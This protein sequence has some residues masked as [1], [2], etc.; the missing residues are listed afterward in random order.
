MLHRSNILTRTFGLLLLL[1]WAVEFSLAVEN[2]L[3][4][5]RREL[6]AAED[7]DDKP[8]I[9]EIARRI[10]VVTPTDDSIWDKLAANQLA[11]E[12]LDRL[13]QTLNAW[14]KVR[15]IPVAGIQDFRGDLAVRRNQ[16]DE[17]ERHWLAFLRSKPAREDAAV[18]YDKLAAASVEQSR[19]IENEKYC[20]QAIAARDSPARRVTHAAAL[21][22]LH[23]W[24]AAY[25]EMVKANKMDSAD[26]AV[27]EWLP[28]FEKLREF[29][30][31]IK[32]WDY[33]LTQNPNDAA[34]LLEQ[35]HLFTKAGRAPLALDNAKRALEL[36][37]AS[38][39]AR[40]QTAEALLD[41]GRTKEANQLQVSSHLVRGKDTHV[42]DAALRA[43]GENDEHISQNQQTATALA[44]RAGTLRELKQYVLALADARAAIQVDEKNAAGHAEAARS[45]EKLDHSREA[46]NEIKRASELAP[47]DPAIWFDRGRIEGARADFPGAIESL[48]RSLKISESLMVLQERERCERRLGRIN[49]ADADAARIGELKEK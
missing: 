2:D 35:A 32:T 14:E 28:E 7:Q 34:A 44:A 42:S 13:E 49:E 29:L 20:A 5:L 38:M 9:V 33:R 36:Q 31:A 18:V 15:K 43:L 17:A 11:L 41:L 40:I 47:N 6:T 39:R 3:G 27:K 21:L 23:R 26:G 16:Y 22:R 8:A 4:R 25:A 48:T 24:D 19:W 37:P 10:V 45:L 30:P 1:L 46:L 12:D